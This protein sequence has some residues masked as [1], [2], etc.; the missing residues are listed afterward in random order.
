[1]PTEVASDALADL[2]RLSLGEASMED[3]IDL[4]EERE[5]KPEVMDGECS[6]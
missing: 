6:V 2:T 1:V 5:F 3:F 4:E